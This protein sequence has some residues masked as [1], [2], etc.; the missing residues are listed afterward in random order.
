MAPE[1]TKMSHY[2]A[3]INQNE[4]EP[5]CRN[6]HSC[7]GAKEERRRKAYYV[8]YSLPEP[9]LGVFPGAIG[10]KECR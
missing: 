8:C 9:R 6:V 7:L 3:R 10:E 2:S 4:P 5:L 1:R